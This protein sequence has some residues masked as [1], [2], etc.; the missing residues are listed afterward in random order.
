M[1]YGVWRHENSIGNSAEHTIG[2]YKELIRNEDPNPTIYVETEF[3]KWFVLCIPGIKPENIKFFP[4][5]LNLSKM[6]YDD[7]YFKD[8]YMPSCYPFAKTYPAVWADLKFEPECTLEF[9]EHLYEPKRDL[10][11]DAIIMHVREKGTYDHRHVGSDEESE[12]FVDP[13]IFKVIALYF[14]KKGH[15]VVR[16]GD[17]NQSPF[18]KHE[19]IFDFALEE[20]T[21]IQEE[22]Y[23]I[24]KCKLY[25]STDSGI[26]PMVGGMKKKLLFTNVASPLAKVRLKIPFEERK[27]V[28]PRVHLPIPAHWPDDWK[29]DRNGNPQGLAVAVIDHSKLKLDIVSWLSKDYTRLIFKHLVWT[30]DLL[31][32][33]LIANRPEEIILQ[34]EDILKNGILGKDGV[35][36]LSKNE[37][38]N[39]NPS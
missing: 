37:Y 28:E 36:T 16:V 27:L 12:R 2:L 39:N 32:G 25:I 35:E 31:N 7:V 14:A 3:Q 11:T 19:N 8:I 4:E 38:Y 5:T 30:E 20:N 17:K 9:P 29:H 34:A 6:D 10:P 1:K 24:S 33:A 23:M 15:K 22:L 13:K 26:W 18:P 21:T